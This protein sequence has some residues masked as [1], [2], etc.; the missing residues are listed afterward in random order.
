MASILVVDDDGIVRDALNVFLTRAGHRVIT[1]ADGAN[2][3][4]AFKNNAPD[5]VILDRNLPGMSGSGVFNN[6]RKLS[7]TTPVIILSGYHEPEEVDAYLRSGA[8]SFFSKGDGLSPVLAE[9]DRLAGGP[10]GRKLPG[11]EAGKPA[12]K[13]AA[14]AA[15]GHCAGVVLIAD[16][17]PATRAVLRRCLA[18]VSYKTLEAKDGAA[19]LKLA[20]GHRP[21]IVL[22]DI[23]M[24]ERNGLEVLI[25]LAAEMPGTGFV[26]ITGNHDEALA[27]ECLKNGAFDYISKPVNLESL[28]TVLNARLLVQ[29]NGYK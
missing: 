2:G 1:A 15:N 3:L 22:L 9:V 18:A 13:G 7:K 5:L 11:P 4:L 20:R 14:A 17:D 27:L 21:D 16:D 8:A 6:I 29:K 19:A 12:G 28:Q 26:M 23:S 10:G 25:E 24:P